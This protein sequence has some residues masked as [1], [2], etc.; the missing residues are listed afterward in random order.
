MCYKHIDECICNERFELS[1]EKEKDIIA[2]YDIAGLVDDYIKQLYNDREVQNAT[3]NKLFHSVYQPLKEA[4]NEGMSQITAKVEFGTP[5]FEMLK[6]LQHNVG[7]F[8]AFKNHSMVKEIVA[9]LKD[10]D[11]NLKPYNKFKQ[12]ALSIDSKYR[13]QWLK[14]EYD[15]AVRQA[16]MAAQWERFQRTKHLYPNLEYVRSKAA[17]PNNDHLLLVGIILPMDDAFWNTRYPPSRF[18]CMCSVKQTDK[19]TTDIPDNLPDVPKEFAF[20]SGKTGQAFSIKNTEYIK[21]ATAAEMPKLIKF[22]KAEVNKDII[23]SLEY[24]TLYDSKKGGG[25]VEVHPLAINNSDYNEV[26]ATARSL[27]N[28]G[29]KIKILPDIVDTQLRKALLPTDKIKGIKNPDYL[30]DSNYVTDLKN[31]NGSSETTIHNALKSCHKQCD[32]IVMVI[33]DENPISYENV[34]RWTKGKL[35][36]DGYKNFENVWINYKGEWKFLTREM[37][38]NDNVG[39]KSK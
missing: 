39:I 11:G 3:N 6:N 34:C 36:Y 25:K 29:K 15:T 21:S 7:V 35:K 16:R 2:K 27:A 20:N 13:E 19:A 17:N 32:N 14:V 24:Q 28:S 5:N 18:G 23:N 10:E 8:A 30:I 37:I 4:I 26:L 9:L 12:D 1:K 31:I 38:L 33:P 22:A